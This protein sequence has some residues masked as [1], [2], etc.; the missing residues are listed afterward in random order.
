MALP[1]SRPSEARR[2]VVAWVLFSVLGGLWALASP[3][4]SVPDEPSHA[5]YA[6]AAV[7]GEVWEPTDGSWTKVRVPADFADAGDIPTCFAFHAEVPAGCSPAFGGKTGTALAKTSA[8]RY[9]PA[10]YLYAGL[11]SLVTTG[12]KALYLMRLLTVVLVAGLLAS[13]TCSVLRTRRPRL[14]LAGMGLAVTPM[15]LYFSGA[16]NP[17]GPEIAASVAIWACG[18]VLLSELR[19]DPTTPL[20]WRNPH[21]RRVLLA[22]GTLSLARPLSLL[23]LALIVVSLLALLITRESARRLITSRTVLC[24]LPVLAL[25]AG[26]TVGWVY[27]RNTLGAQA[28]TAYGHTPIYGAANISIAKINDELLQMIGVFG[29]LDTSSP[30]IVYATF[31]AALGAMALLALVLGGRRLGIVVGLLA[32]AVMGIPVFGELLTYKQDAFPWQGRYTLPIAVGVPLLLAL[33][34]ATSER[35]LQLPAR[36]LAT[37]FAA[38]FV[39]VDVVAFVGTL[40]RYVHTVNGFFFVS[41]T[42][43]SP[44]VPVFVLVLG[45]LVAVTACCVVALRLRDGEEP[46]FED[47]A[48][49]SENWDDDA[50]GF[51]THRLATGFERDSA[52][53]TRAEVFG[54][55]RPHADAGASPSPR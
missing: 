32:I 51:D 46:A 27:L 1:L 25:A 3:L 45:M 43:W 50:D 42:Q 21:L 52:G 16:V 14:A 2:W 8:G 12:A 5:V 13:A 37:A 53:P 22:V 44:P 30:G 20:T 26:S 18:F 9:P 55:R 24:S 36:R 17:Q 41:P 23:W 38:V 29:W 15:V 10:Y 48:P 6:A 28:I 31:L 33:T 11:G 34:V 39:L 49:F 47:A 4:F 19:R 35:H 54:L 7:R 40:N